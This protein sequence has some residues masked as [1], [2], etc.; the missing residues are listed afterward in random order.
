MV[1]WLEGEDEFEDRRR[2]L[3][4]S[5]CVQP[6]FAC[7]N[8]N[9]QAAMQVNE[10]KR[11]ESLDS[12]CLHGGVDRIRRYNKHIVSEQGTLQLLYAAC[13]SLAGCYS[14]QKPFSSTDTASILARRHQLRCLC[15]HIWHNARRT[16]EIAPRNNMPRNRSSEAH[17]YILRSACC[18]SSPISVPPMPM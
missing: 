4:G 18:P 15:D 10:A 5:F 11:L 6:W 13:R 9:R 8:P 16:L 17:F 2:Q 14:S 12:F 1:G 3:L 7:I